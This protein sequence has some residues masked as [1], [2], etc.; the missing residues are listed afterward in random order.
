MKLLFLKESVARAGIQ[1]LGVTG[2][3][4]DSANL[5]LTDK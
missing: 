2:L 4:I 3:E 5:G 1:K